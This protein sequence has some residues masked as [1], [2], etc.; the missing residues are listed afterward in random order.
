M[1]NAQKAAQLVLGDRNAS[2]GDPAHDYAKVAK[3]WSG[4]LNPILARD[5]TPSEAILMMVGLKL[6]REVYRPGQDN[7]IDAH[8]YL[9]CYDWARSGVRPERAD[10]TALAK[11]VLRENQL[12]DLRGLLNEALD[13]LDNHDT[14]A[15]GGGPLVDRIRAKLQEDQS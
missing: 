1:D 14:E 7:I 6:A 8:G 4:L 3:I 15:E 11:V 5:I 12:D 9:L 10:E 13:Y 2:Y